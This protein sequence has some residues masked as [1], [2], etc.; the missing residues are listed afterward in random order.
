[1]RGKFSAQEFFSSLVAMAAQAATNAFIGKKFSGIGNLLP[2]SGVGKGELVGFTY[3]GPE[4]GFTGPVMKYHTG[5]YA[6]LGAQRRNLPLAAF[7][8]APRFHYGGG[9][10]G[11]DEYPAILLRG[12]RVLNREETRA[13]DAQGASP[14]N[15]GG[16]ATPVV[17]IN[18]SN[19]TGAEV[20]AQGQARPDGKG[21]FSLDILLSQV[22]QGLVARAKSGKS[23]LMQYQEK[24]YGMGRAPVIAR[25]RGRA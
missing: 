15:A 7:A 11:Q 19:A 16:N 14:V 22:E 23:Q 21:G 25:G 6:G 4:G 18:I 20:E 17:N 9:F 13:Y 5:G 24:A 1:M 3:A 10:F 2:S 12:E 8:N